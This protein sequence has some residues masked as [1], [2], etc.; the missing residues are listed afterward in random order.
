MYILYQIFHLP[1]TSQ[2]H[3]RSSTLFTKLSFCKFAGV[4]NNLPLAGLLVHDAI[5]TLLCHCPHSVHLPLNW[6]HCGASL[7]QCIPSAGPFEALSSN[8]EQ[9]STDDQV[10]MW[11][12]EKPPHSLVKRA[13]FYF[14][15]LYLGTQS[16]LSQIYN[17]TSHLI[18]C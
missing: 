2:S 1:G 15:L 12:K 13:F 9:L 7:G 3:S 17:K 16:C 18:W 4:S 10:Q 11:E 5:C 8:W 6:G 14:I